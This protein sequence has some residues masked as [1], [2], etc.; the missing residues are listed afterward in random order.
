MLGLQGAYTQILFDGQ[1]TM[2]SLAQVYGIEQIPSR[3]IERIEVVKGGGSAVYGPGSVGGVINVISRK[4]N[5]TSGFLFGRMEWMNGTPNQSLSASGEWASRD[6]NSSVMAFG[7]ADRVNP[8]DIDNDGLTEVAKREFGAVGVRYYQNFL[9]QKG[10]LSFDFNHIREDRRGGDRLHLPP[11]QANIAEAIDSR[12]SAGGI[13]WHHTPNTGFDYRLALS[14]ARTDRDTYYGSAMDPNA[15]GESNNGLWVLDSQFNHFLSSHILSWG[16]QLSSDG[17]EDVQPAYD[18]FY[19]STYRNMG[20]FI[21]DDWFFLPGFELIYGGRLDKHSEISSA[22]FSP[23]VALMW[24]AKPTLTFRTSVA[25]GFLPPQVFDEDLHITQVGGEGQIIRNGE[26]LNEEH[27]AT[28]MAG[29]EWKPSWGKGVGLVEVNFFH[30]GIKDLFHIIEDDDPETDEVEFTRINFGE[31]KV[32][33]TEINVGYAITTE[34]ELQAGYVEQRSRFSEAE[35]D[36]GSKDFFRTPDRYGMATVI[37]RNPRFLD[38]FFGARFTGQMKVPH[39]AGYIPE[40]RLETSP[41][42]WT[43]DA[44]IS[45]SFPFGSDSK[46]IFTFGGKNLTNYYQDDLDRGIYRDSGYLWGPRFPRTLYVST[47][48]EF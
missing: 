29:L 40:D 44:S 42:H 1:P 31:A 11:D 7:Q 8:L 23:R 3:M 26:E 22:I 35:P 2:S 14:L 46:I 33:G 30:T 48:V 17:I 15:Y 21:Q 12:R 43:V 45:K 27:S 24:S 19:E 36:F 47:G 10:E 20:I 37:Y 39:Y 25:T 38:L 5:Q 13:S 34:L 41:A 28:V 6:R 4:P 32:Y 9:D 18:R 16:G